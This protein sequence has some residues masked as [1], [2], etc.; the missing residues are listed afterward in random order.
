LACLHVPCVCSQTF[1]QYC[2]PDCPDTWSRTRTSEMSIKFRRVANRARIITRSS[3]ALDESHARPSGELSVAAVTTIS[4]V[5]APC[6]SMPRYPCRNVRTYTRYKSPRTRR[7]TGVRFS[8]TLEPGNSTC[9]AHHIK[10]TRA[11]RGIPQR[12]DSLVDWSRGCGC[13]RDTRAGEI[14]NWLILI[15]GFVLRYRVCVH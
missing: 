2:N 1:S 12:S 14:A 13:E 3:R 9:A 4:G 8:Q 15:N 5:I 6:R 11:F 10:S 7:W